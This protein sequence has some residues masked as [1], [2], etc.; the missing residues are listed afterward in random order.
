MRRL[1]RRGSPK[2]E[3]QH[4]QYYPTRLLSVLHSAQI[5]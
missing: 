5:V 4:P 2:Q 1:G 3:Q